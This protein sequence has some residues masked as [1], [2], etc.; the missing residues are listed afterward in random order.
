MKSKFSML[1]ALLLSLYVSNTTAQSKPYTI[2]GKVTSFE[3]SLAL[4]GVGIY[5]KG[6]KYFTGTQADGTFSLDILPE[7]KILVFELKD[8]ET[9]EIKIT[10]K[11]DYDIVLK[12]T[13]S[14]VQAKIK[15]QDSN[16]FARLSALADDYS[17]LPL[18]PLPLHPFKTIP[19]QPD[20]H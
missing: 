12:R 2:S 15:E 14:L 5:V 4:E 13:N 19:T 20:A 3:E 6:S 16:A 1:V 8:Y 18:F 7:N 17:V 9:L 10:G 11:K